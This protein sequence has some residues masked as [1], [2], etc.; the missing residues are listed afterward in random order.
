MVS[1]LLW[2]RSQPTPLGANTPQLMSLVHLAQSRH[3]DRDGCISS[4]ASFPPIPGLGHVNSV[5][6][7]PNAED[8]SASPEVDFT[9][10]TGFAE[11]GLVYAPGAQWVGY[12]NVSCVQHL[13]G[14]W[15]EIARSNAE[16]GQGCPGGFETPPGP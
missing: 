9:N 6:R 7:Y 4:V 5:C 1:A 16:N 10:G 11:W 13:S 14:P 3:V 2:T 15:F 12:D 8:P